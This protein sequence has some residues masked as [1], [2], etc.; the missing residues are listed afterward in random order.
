MT[1]NS[2]RGTYAPWGEP[3]APAPDAWWSSLVTIPVLLGH[4]VTMLSVMAVF[5]AINLIVNPGTWW[6]LAVL[7]LWLALVIIHAIGVASLRFLLEEDEAEG[8]APPRVHAEPHGPQTPGGFDMLV[9][10]RTGKPVPGSWELTRNDSVP[11][12]PQAPK[13]SETQSTEP[14]IDVPNGSTERVPWRAATDIAWLRR[15]RHDAGG[16]EQPER[17]EEASS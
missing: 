15:P 2:N 8:V 11:S 3:T 12:W 13:A 1:Q 17:N 10:E 6:S 5:S 7:V 14:R 4:I 9:H 16:Q